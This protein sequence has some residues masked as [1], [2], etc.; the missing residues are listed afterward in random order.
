MEE[1][2]KEWKEEKNKSFDGLWDDMKRDMLTKQ[3]N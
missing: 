2:L 3:E 1:Q